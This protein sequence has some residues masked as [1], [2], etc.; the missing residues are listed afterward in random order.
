MK[1]LCI[2]PARGGS[3]GIPRKNLQLVAGKPLIAWSIE[4]ALA[5][6]SVDRLI[7]STDDK[8]IAETAQQRGAEIIIRPP[9]LSGDTA[10]S[11]SALLHVLDAL[12]RGKPYEPD[13]VVFLQPTSP[14]RLAADIDGAVNLLRQGGYDSVFSACP[15]HFTGRWSLDADAYAQPLNFDP[16]RRPRRQDRPVEYLENG[17]LYVFK[18]HILRTTGA[19][20]GGRIGIYVMPAE[21]SHQIDSIE[22]LEFMDKLMK[23]VAG[24]L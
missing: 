23:G 13:V 17:S 14:Y 18:P 6:K 21:R 16:A 9:E 22:D 10:T 20:M 11:E 8:Q 5:S 7:V 19:R 1:T 3:R 12:L 2:I 4:T 15:E 24:D